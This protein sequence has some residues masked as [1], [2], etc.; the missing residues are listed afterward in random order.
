MILG[1]V[2]DLI[3]MPAEAL[4][5]NRMCLECHG[6]GVRNGTDLNH[7]LSSRPEEG[8]TCESCH[9]PGSEY[10]SIKVMSDREAFLAAGGRIPDE[11]TCRSCHRRSENFDWSEK[12]PK[13]AHPRPRTAQLERAD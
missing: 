12:W 4:P 10:I 1:P 6:V 7:A 8:V 3:R 13:I 11:A 5:E 2:T 9:G